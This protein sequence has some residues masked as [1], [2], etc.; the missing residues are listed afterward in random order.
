MLS[1]PIEDIKNRLDVVDIL[2]GYVKLQKAGAN[3]RALCPFHSEKTPSF[4]VSPARQVWRCFGC[5]IGGDIFKFIMQ[6]DGVEFGDALRLLAQRAGVELQ[7][8]SPLFIKLQ[9]ERKRLFE[10]T[11]WATK[12]FEAQF[13]STQGKEVKAYLLKRGFSEESIAAWRLGYAPDSAHSLFNFLQNKGFRADDIHKAGLLVRS[14]QDAYDRF[15]SRVM[16]PIFDLN[17]HIAGFGG[18]IFGEKAHDKEIA[19]YINTSNTPLYDKSRILYGLDRAKMAIRQKNFSLL[20]E[21][22]VDTVLVSQAGFS[23]V[24]AVSGTALTP[25]HLKLLRRYSDNVYLSFDMDVGGDTATKRGIDLAIAEGFNVKI[26]T[27]EEGKDPADVILENPLLWSKAVENAKSIFD[28]YFDQTLQRYS[29][30]T[31]EGKKEISRILLPL[32]KKVPNRIEQSHWIGVLA[33]ELGSKEEDI[34]AE[35]KKLQDAQG[36]RILFS[37]DTNSKIVEVKTRRQLLEE[38]I[39]ILLLRQPAL[40]SNVD[41][42]KMH[43]FSLQSQEVLEALYRGSGRSGSEEPSGSMRQG[44]IDFD[45]LESLLSKELFEFLQHISLRAGIEDW[46]REEGAE[47]IALEFKNCITELEHVYMRN[48]LDEISHEINSAEQLKDAQRLKTLMEQ[49]RAMSNM[50]HLQA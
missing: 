6:I 39:C 41:E 5:G 10:I 11:E 49:F 40:L 25:F 8:A 7:K 22:Y 45:A 16:F 4:F 48:K 24:I 18:R 21:G 26:V 27:V 33:K 50:L 20:V 44:S 32:I 1:S 28:F 12:F 30:K 19:K 43:C 35:L 9:T 3:Y 31:A 13:V 15:R 17:S 34:H 23:N 38:R 47:D 29:T 37:S 14:G 46:E 2:G 36:S 42:G